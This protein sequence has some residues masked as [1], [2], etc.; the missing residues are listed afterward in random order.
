MTAAPN[1]IPHQ[2]MNMQ[3]L[4]A[5]PLPQAITNEDLRRFHALATLAA[6]HPGLD[7]LLGQLANA[8]GVD[9]VALRRPDEPPPHAN[10]IVVAPLRLREAFLGDLYVAAPSHADSVLLAARLAFFAP[11]VALA[12]DADSAH[13]GPAAWRENVQSEH[14][15]LEAVLEATNDAILVIDTA[16]QLVTVTPPFEVFTGIPRY[17]VLGHP[18]EALAQA[19][20]ARPELPRTL[21]N[22]LRALAA[23]E[24]DSL[25]GELEIHVPERRILTWCSVPVYFQDGG[26]LGRSVTFRD[27]TRERDVDRLKT[28]FITLVSHELRTPLTSVKG[29][30]DLILESGE[31]LPDDLREYLTIIALNADRLVTLINDIIDITRIENDRVELRPT[32]CELS[33]VVRNIANTLEPLLH[34][35]GHTLTL[36]IP[37]DLP[38]VWADRA[39]TAQIVS[40]L[41]SNAIK[42]T[43][44]GGHLAIRAR[45]I[46]SVDDLPPAT[47]SDPIVPCVLVVVEDDGLGIAAED[48]PHLFKRFYRATNELT[49]QIGGTGLGLMIVKSFVE[50][51]GGQVWFE[52]ELGQ[53]STFYFTM[54]VIEGQA[55]AGD[56]HR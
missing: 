20:E 23:N 15:R 34:E 25:G 29:F 39:R 28:E 49:R 26:L 2:P 19:I 52:S 14:D 40:N 7:L 53:G 21:A 46:Q 17:S 33:E 55:L 45:F 24:T 3:S 36:D 43:L 22:V 11:A 54:P 50:M 56:T 35:R 18:A 6:Q 51:Q 48:R 5:Q 44:Q 10:R 13:T 31:D 32:P 38:P 12:L 47:R 42:Y 8:L 4:S 41:L 9:R 16:G 30:S 37:P 27:V 1:G